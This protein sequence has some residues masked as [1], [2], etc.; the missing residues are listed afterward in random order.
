MTSP[1]R[2]IGGGRFVQGSEK[3][4]DLAAFNRAQ[5]QGAQFGDPG[6]GVRGAIAMVDD[7][8]ERRELACMHIGRALADPAQG[9]DLERPD[10]R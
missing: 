9:R 1:G 6:G 10:L 5:V 8:S 2:R 7:L 4:D 3:R